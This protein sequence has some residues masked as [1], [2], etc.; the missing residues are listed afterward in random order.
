MGALVTVFSLAVAL[1]VLTSWWDWKAWSGDD[2]YVDSYSGLGGGDRRRGAGDSSRICLW[3]RKPN[4]STN[5]SHLR[6]AVMVR[7]VRELCRVLGSGSRGT[8][9]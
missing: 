8:A 4:E 5:V 7:A 3:G 1:D 6:P 9:G 2:Q